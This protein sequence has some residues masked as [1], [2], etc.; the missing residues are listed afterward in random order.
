MHRKRYQ[1]TVYNNGE[2]V[3]NKINKRRAK[4]SHKSLCRKPILF[5]VLIKTA[6]ISI[7]RI[8]VT[9]LVEDQWNPQVSEKNVHI[10]EVYKD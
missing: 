6:T 2:K 1:Y 8:C 10:D 9:I 7:C 5:K 3:H 4:V